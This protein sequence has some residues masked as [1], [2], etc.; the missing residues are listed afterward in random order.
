MA[1]SRSGARQ[2]LDVDGV[3]MHGVDSG[4]TGFNL[5]ATGASVSTASSG[6][7][8]SHDAG[9]RTRTGSFSVDETPVNAPVLLCQS[10][11]RVEIEFNDGSGV[12]TF[13]ALIQVTRDF[14][15]RGQR[16]FTVACTV[17]GANK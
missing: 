15:A 9:Y 2:T 7:T 10:G 4:F 5:N 1:T 17:D 8:T 6:L 14:N 12:Q 3:P 11:Q 13:D 16:T